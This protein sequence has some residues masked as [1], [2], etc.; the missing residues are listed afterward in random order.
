M[1]CGACIRRGSRRFLD[2][3]DLRQ[4]RFSRGNGAGEKLIDDQALA[5]NSR[6]CT[7]DCLQ[8]AIK[9]RRWQS[10]RFP[11]LEDFLAYLGTQRECL[12]AKL[13]EHLALNF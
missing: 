1:R 5:G 7:I 9:A 12:G 8:K 13:L 6:A 3:F 11:L 2:Y 10:A 4:C